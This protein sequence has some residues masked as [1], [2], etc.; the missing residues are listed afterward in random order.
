MLTGNQSVPI[1]SLCYFMLI[2]ANWM[3]FP[4]NIFFALTR[5][6]MVSLHYERILNLCFRGQ[7]TFKHHFLVDHMFLFQENMQI[8][9]KNK[10]K[11][12]YYCQRFKFY[13]NDLKNTWKL[14]GTLVKRKNEGQ[15]CPARVISNTKCSL[16]NLILLSSSISILLM[17]APIWQELSTVLTMIHVGLLTI[18]L[19]IVFFCLLLQKSGLLT[20]S[21]A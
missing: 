15:N 16:I 19:Y 7:G 12:D 21:L 13:Q 20:F 5:W 4:K 1:R 6:D 11:N 9:I 18:L 14:I 17:L 10:A 8:R 3:P 2:Y